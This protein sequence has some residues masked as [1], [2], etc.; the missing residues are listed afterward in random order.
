MTSPVATALA[1]AFAAQQLL[2]GEA[3]TYARPGGI[4]VEISRAVRGSTNWST[5]APFPGSR[6]GERS[7]DWL[8]TVADLTTADGTVLEPQ[9]S[10]TITTGNGEVFRVLPM[11]N[12]S[13]LWQWHD[14][15]GQSI[16]RIFTKERS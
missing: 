2:H 5:D 14:R 15:P 3:V 13:P 1:T 11:S 16:R 4:S 7:T 8:L 10:D 9:R 12:D 6:I